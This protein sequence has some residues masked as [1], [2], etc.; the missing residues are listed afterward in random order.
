MILLDAC[1]LINLCATPVW[2][3]V[4][5]YI[6][7]RFPTG[8]RACGYGIGYNA[9]AATGAALPCPSQ[10]GRAIGG[11]G[12][13]RVAP[14]RSNEKPFFSLPSGWARDRRYQM[15]S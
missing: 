8:V 9:P 13:L 14:V 1:V 15:T 5:A 10:A 3:F 2:A 7:E 11:T 4:T 6:N 12:G